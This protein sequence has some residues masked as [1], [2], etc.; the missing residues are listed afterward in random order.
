MSNTELT[1]YYMGL[2]CT[3]TNKL[4][5]VAYTD[6][7]ST[8]DKHFNGQWTWELADERFAMDNTTVCT[9]ITLY[10]PGKIYTGRSLCKIKDYSENH[11]FAILDACK[12]FMAE[13]KVI[14]PQQSNFNSTN[15]QMTPE[16]IMN[17]L[18]Q[19]PQQQVNTVAQFYNYKD[20]LGM[21]SNNVPFEAIT[22]NCQKE[23]QQEYINSSSQPQKTTLP[24]QGNADYNAPQARYKGFSQC[25]IDKLNQFKKDF[26]ILNDQ[27]FGNYVNTWDKSLTSKSDITPANADAFLTWVENLGKMDC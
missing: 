14:Q 12:S 20:E 16:Q 10:T 11:L 27:M 17:A 23:L 5:E 7:I 19:Q 1:K 15:Q 9:T 21:P 25:Q 24:Q 18:G 8:L 3:T 6:I 13:N 2:Q 22:D 26:D 4:P